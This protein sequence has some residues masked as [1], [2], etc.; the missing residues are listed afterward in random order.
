[1]IV[2][3]YILISN[4]L[5]PG[6]SAIFPLL[7]PIMWEIATNIMIT[8]NCS[9]SL[10]QNKKIMSEMSQLILMATFS[11]SHFF[12]ASGDGLKSRPSP[13]YRSKYC[14]LGLHFILSVL[15]CL[16]HLYG[17]I[18]SFFF[19]QVSGHLFSWKGI[20][21]FLML[22]QKLMRLSVHHRVKCALCSQDNDLF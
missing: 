13:T 2:L 19:T 8:S 22:M 11:P 1:M 5:F 7:F 4:C 20:F 15:I 16:S 21:N 9:E 10:D 14:L 17:Y 12:G 3:Y 6:S 18:I